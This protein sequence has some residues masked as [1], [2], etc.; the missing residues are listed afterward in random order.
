M[1]Y[2]INKLAKLAGITTRALR[3][4]DKIGLLK[5]N[6]INSSGYRI[7]GRNELNLLQQILLYRE[8][9]VSLEDIKAI[10]SSPDFDGVI[11]LENHL[12]TLLEKR[13]QINLLI[14]NVEKTILAAKGEITMSDREKFEGFKQN[15]I[16]GNEQKYGAEIRKKYGDEVID[17]S[18]EKLRGMSEEDY[19]ESEKI[20]LEFEEALKTAFE[21]G[22]P[23]D[24]SAQKAYELHKK[25]LCYFYDGYSKEYHKGLAEMYVADE[26]FRANY[27]KIA[28]SC[29]EFLREAIHSY[30]R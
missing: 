19:N 10:I 18:N 5:P 23:L 17:K 13:N 7:Y 12:S 15:L 26:R 1:E 30:C 25:W 22:D 16:D 28:P 9:G 27:D 4:Y 21:Q 8:L 2:T 29:T 20:R 14:A 24:E 3:H 6:R 11:A